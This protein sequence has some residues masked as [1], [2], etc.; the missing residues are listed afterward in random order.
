MNNSNN[1]VSSGFWGQ[2]TFIPTRVENVGASAANGYLLHQNYPNPFRSAT[3]ITYTIPAESIVHVK[4][5]N[6]AGQ[7]VSYLVNSGNEGPGS[8]Q[9]IWDGHF[10]NGAKASPGTYFYQITIYGH[11]S[12]T[13]SN[14]ILFQQTKKMVIVR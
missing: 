14:K 4:I 9:K 2:T 6:L 8:I 12:R 10:D 13:A 11:Q 1:K 7:Q 5:Y 3:T